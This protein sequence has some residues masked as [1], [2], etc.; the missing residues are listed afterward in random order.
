MGKIIVVAGDFCPQSR[1]AEKLEHEDYKFVL[2]AIKDTLT[3]VEYSIVNFECPVVKGGELPIPKQGP[4]LHCTEKGIEAVKLA[5]FNCVTL[6]NNHFRDYGDSGVYSTLE[7]CKNYNLDTVGGGKNRNEASQI[8]YKNID[9]VE[10]AIINCCEN[11][12][13][14]ATETTAGSNPLN[15]VRQYYAIKEAR[16]KADFILVITH[17][18]HE[19]WQLPS[20]RMVET[21]RFLVDAGADAVVNHHQHCFSGYEVYNGKPIFYGLGN[22]CFDR[23]EHQNDIWNYGYM[24]ELNLLDTLKFRLIPYKQ[25][26][27]KPSVEILN[28]VKKFNQEIEELNK[29]IADS[30]LLQQK[31]DD[32]YRQ[33]ARET[34]FVFEPFY[35]TIIERL[36]R[37]GLLKSLLSKRQ[38]IKLRNMVCCESHRDKTI[39]Y[40]THI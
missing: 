35:G 1:V 14:I 15:P 30:V 18:G 13:S 32:Y 31:T 20:P 6:A 8:L 10:L 33:S 28:D 24:V 37:K 19:M 29:I 27:E 7:A 23:P 34:R 11:E 4:N 12:F 5:G 38:L 9:G 36:L 39:Y 2:G 16:K 26:G 22:F 17:G 3:E 25:C 40:L 21:Y